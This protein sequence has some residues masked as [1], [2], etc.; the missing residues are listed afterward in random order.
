M[1]RQTRKILFIILIQ[2]YQKLFTGFIA[3]MIGMIPHHH[4]IE[5]IIIAF[6]ICK[7]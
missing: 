7:F 4:G 1:T 3:N 6:V 5:I 2:Q